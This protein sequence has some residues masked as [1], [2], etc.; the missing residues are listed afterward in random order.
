MDLHVF[1]TYMTY[2]GYIFLF[3][4]LLFYTSLPRHI[5]RAALIYH[6][7][8]ENK[9]DN[10][11]IDEPK[12]E[13]QMDL[14]VKEELKFEDKYLTAFKSFSNDYFFTE[15]ELQ[16]KS[17]KRKQLVANFNTSYIADVDN[18]TVLLLSLRMNWTRI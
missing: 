2:T 7:S 15:E 5:K 13:E 1:Q 9:E 17:E 14:V 16:E 11:A 18:V 10:Y 6:R 3:Y 12:V 8:A 4:Y